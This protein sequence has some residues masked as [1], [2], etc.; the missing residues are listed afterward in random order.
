[1]R[2]D[3]KHQGLKCFLVIIAC[4]KLNTQLVVTGKSYTSTCS[5]TP[6]S[7]FK[8]PSRLRSEDVQEKP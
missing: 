6:S 8:L 1:M 7:H 5:G 3:V 4:G 2:H